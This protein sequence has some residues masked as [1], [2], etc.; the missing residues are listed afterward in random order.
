MSS[1]LTIEMKLASAA[2]TPDG[3][4][5]SNLLD[6]SSHWLHGY[7]AHLSRSWTLASGKSL[8]VRPIRHDRRRARGS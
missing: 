6:D 8:R 4:H 1:P 5:D 2:V 3:H 7:P